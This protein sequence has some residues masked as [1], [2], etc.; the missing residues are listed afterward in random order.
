[1]HVSIRRSRDA[2]TDLRSWMGG[3]TVSAGKGP[4]DPVPPKPAYP[5]DGLRQGARGDLVEWLQRRLNTIAGKNG[6]GALG[7]R[8]LT[9]DGIFGKDT[10]AV[11]RVF[12]AHRGLPASGRVDQSTWQRL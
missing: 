11:V 5:K 6:H 1:M 2:E 3:A 12:Q 10:E 7:G 8:A 4:V 9:P